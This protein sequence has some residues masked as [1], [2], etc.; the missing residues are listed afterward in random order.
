[1]AVEDHGDMGQ[2]GLSK[3]HVGSLLTSY[4]TSTGIAL[5]CH[6]AVKNKEGLYAVRFLLGLVSFTII[7]MKIT[8]L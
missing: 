4:P 6:A 1:M 3:T 8:F 5:A 7:L 2:V